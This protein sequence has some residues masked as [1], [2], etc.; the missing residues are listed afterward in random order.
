MRAWADGS[1]EP[2]TWQ[3]SATNSLGGLQVAGSFGMR[4]YAGSRITNGPLVVSVDD[5][6]A[7]SIDQ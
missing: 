3:Y 7:T 4:V 1:S 6:R 2:S 5:L